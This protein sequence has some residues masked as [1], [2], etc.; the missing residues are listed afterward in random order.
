MKTE[1]EASI[2]MRP[3]VV[4]HMTMSLDGR[5]A[6]SRWELSREG[7][8]EYEATAA[9]YQAN[10]WMCGRIT[11]AAFARGTAN[12][13]GSDTSSIPKT[14]Y[15]APHPQASYAVAI[16]PSGKLYWTTSDISGD[17]IITVLTERVSSAY[18]AHLQSRQ[19]SYLFAG[20]DRSDLPMVLE[21][22]ATRFQIKTLLL[23]GGGK[24]NGTML[25]A[26]LIDELSLLLAPFADGSTGTPALFDTLDSVTPDAASVRWRLHTLERRADDIV[27]LRYRQ[28]T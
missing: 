19:I 6:S 11:M 7:R 8:A 1:R 10:A 16:D 12:A 9:T 20:R 17:H 28:S 15:I 14:D 13:P 3:Y 4:C 2:C 27:W 22:L 23:E 18:L 21:K 5:I 25:R 26:G 24:I